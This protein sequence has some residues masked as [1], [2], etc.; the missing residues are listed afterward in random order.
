MVKIVDDKGKIVDEK[1]RARYVRG[2][3]PGA[4]E[5]WCLAH[6]DTSNPTEFLPLKLKI[7][8][9]RFSVPILGI[10]KNA[11]VFGPMTMHGLQLPTCNNHTQIGIQ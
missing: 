6:R 8:T 2:V 7:R 4:F 9:S 5:G 3:V 11:I 10:E 1:G